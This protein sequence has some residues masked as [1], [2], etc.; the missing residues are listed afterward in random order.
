MLCSNTA[1]PCAAGMPAG[2]RG[3]AVGQ[4]EQPAL[5]PFPLMRMRLTR[6]SLKQVL[7]V[8]PA[9]VGMNQAGAGSKR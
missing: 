8:A 6:Q 1:W 3:R 9:G 5:F 4:G 7:Q 2:R